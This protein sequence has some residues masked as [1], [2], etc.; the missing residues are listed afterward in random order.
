MAV[1]DKVKARKDV[2]PGDD[3]TTEVKPTVDALV[4]E[5]DI[6]T[7]TLLV[8]ISYLRVLL[9]RGKSLRTS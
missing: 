7:D 8:K 4:A 1:D 5:L 9:A 6:M 2:L 3:D